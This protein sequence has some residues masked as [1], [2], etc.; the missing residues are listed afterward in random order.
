[1]RKLILFIALIS[2]G[3][4]VGCSKDGEVKTFLTKF[5]SVTKEMTKKIESG[6]ID[7]AKKHF[8]ENKVDLKTGFDS[9]K[10]AR[11]IQ[12]SAETKKE[13]ESSVMS[14]MKA[15]SAA[16][17]KAAIGAAG[18]KAKVE[19]LQALLKDYANLFKM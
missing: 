12:V 11:E 9:F 4:A 2:C 8:E 1:M 17:S 16:A 3:L 15:L 14:N 7:G 13:L 19:T 5:E 18:D 10:N 6:D